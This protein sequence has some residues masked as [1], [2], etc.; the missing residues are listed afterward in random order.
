MRI[1]P[2]TNDDHIIAEVR[3]IN[4]YR[5]PEQFGPTDIIIDVGAHIGAFADLC[6]ERGAGHCYCFEACGDNYDLAEQ[7]LA[8]YGERAQIRHA[9]IIGESRTRPATVRFTGMTRFASG[10]INSGGGNVLWPGGD[11]CIGHSEECRAL[12]FDEVVDEILPPWRTI[13]L[14]KLDCEASEFPILLTSQQLPWIDEIVGEFHEVG[15][16]QYAA[17]PPW[18]KVEGHDC[19][20]VRD[21]ALRLKSYGFR[22]EIEVAPGSH[23][24]KF[25]ARRR[26]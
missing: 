12:S 17:L 25:F 15:P 4:A 22:T 7:N 23:I 24:G 8:V 16:E 10:L 1:R 21:I 2:G 3:G 19:Y 11:N 18:A 20:R 14:L 5:L 26:N 13:R 6:L 9:A